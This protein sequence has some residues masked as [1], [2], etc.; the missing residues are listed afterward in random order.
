MMMMKKRQ[1][2]AMIKIDLSES[3]EPL[4]RSGD[5]LSASYDLSNYHLLSSKNI[6]LH[7]T[8]DEPMNTNKKLSVTHLK[9]KIL[10]RISFDFEERELKQFRS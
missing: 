1:A 3:D 5:L 8:K 2:K 7:E 4:T 9:D 10:P 6:N